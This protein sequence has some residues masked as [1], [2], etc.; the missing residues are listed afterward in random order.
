M[1]GW[2]SRARE[3]PPISSGTSSS[4]TSAGVDS[5]SAAPAAPP[6][7]VTRARRRTRPAWPASSWRENAAAETVYPTSATVLVTFA[8]S[9]GS[10]TASRAGYDTNDARP[11]T[12]PAT[13]A[14]T[15]DQG[16]EDHVRA[17]HRLDST[18]PSRGRGR[19]LIGA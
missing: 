15:G 2:S 17:V 4:N 1:P 11:A 19:P 13:P 7:V 14:R 9:G 18:A 6:A 5:S 12:E 16:E 8:V 3:A 10:P